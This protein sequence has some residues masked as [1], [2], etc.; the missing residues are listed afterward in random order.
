M[1]LEG[2]IVLFHTVKKL[3]WFGQ[4]AISLFFHPVNWDT[5]PNL[6]V[7]KE[8]W[9]DI[10]NELCFDKVG[11]EPIFV[12]SSAWNWVQGAASTGA[13]S[14]DEEDEYFESIDDHLDSIDKTLNHG[15]PPHLVAF[16]KFL[17][18]LSGPVKI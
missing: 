17:L 14:G 1:F 2:L 16:G 18:E 10:E 4:T 6:K 5:A 13:S 11:G 8:V 3:D 9:T 7:G 12:D 15:D